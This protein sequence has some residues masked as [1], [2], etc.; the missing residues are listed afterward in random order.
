MLLDQKKIVLSPVFSIPIR[1][2]FAQSLLSSLVVYR[3]FV[4]ALV[5]GLSP[6]SCASISNS[7]FWDLE[8]RV[9]Q[10]LL[11]LNF[12][13]EDNILILFQTDSRPTSYY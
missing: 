8:N 6:V 10:A 4:A 11:L 5:R 3:Q 7:L 1:S 2:G 13:L 12:S 9:C